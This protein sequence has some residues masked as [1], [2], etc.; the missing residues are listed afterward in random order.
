M[1]DYDILFDCVFI[2]GAVVS[3]AALCLDLYYRFV[4]YRSA[5]KPSGTSKRVI[6]LSH[7]TGGNKSRPADAA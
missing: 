4:S 6:A 7:Q 1:T 3:Y 2:Y 5:R